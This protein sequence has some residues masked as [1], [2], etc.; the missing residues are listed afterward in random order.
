MRVIVQSLG[1]FPPAEIA[2]KAVT[3]WHVRREV[4][5]GLAASGHLAAMGLRPAGGLFRWLRSVPARFRRDALAGVPA[6]MPI[7]VA[8]SMPYMRDRITRALVDA[9]HLVRVKPSLW[10]RLFPLPAH[11]QTIRQGLPKAEV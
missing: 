3:S 4:I 5:A 6:E 11:E 1:G 9:G 2:A 10:R 8:A 7:N